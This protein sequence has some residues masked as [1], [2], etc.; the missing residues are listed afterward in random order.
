MSQ[1]YLHRHKQRWIQDMEDDITVTGCENTDVISFS[2]GMF[3]ADQLAKA[4]KWQI[5]E[6]AQKSCE[7]LKQ[8]HK[9][10]IHTQVFKNGTD[11]E[12]LSPKSKGWKKGKFKVKLELEFIPAETEDIQGFES[13]SSGLDSLRSK[14]DS[15]QE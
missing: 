11:C 2:T 3:R 7:L 13:Y 6:I 5:S 12:V 15:S 9:I 1:E 14:I 4:F 8:N 10:E